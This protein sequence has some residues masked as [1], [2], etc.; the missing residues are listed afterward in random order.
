MKRIFIICLCLCLFS[1]GFVFAQVENN[2]IND[3]SN[4]SLIYQSTND[5]VNRLIYILSFITAAL[6]ASFLIGSGILIYRQI[7]V[8]KDIKAQ[9]DRIIA[10]GRDAELVQ[11]NLKEKEKSIEEKMKDINK[12]TKKVDLRKPKDIEELKN[13]KVLIE[14]LEKDIKN[15]HREIDF[16]KGKVSTVSGV[17]WKTI[18]DFYSSNDFASKGMMTVGGNDL[19]AF[20]AKTNKGILSNNQPGSKKIC[21]KCFHE[22]ESQAKFCSECGKKF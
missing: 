10:I 14:E 7:D 4:L 19:S 1:V 3:I 20:T 22:N 17:D 12:K 13:T 16:Q 15:M 9:R 6:M 11:K 21:S 5:S 8:E 2:E 18:N